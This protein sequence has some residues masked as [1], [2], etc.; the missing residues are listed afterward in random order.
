MKF[1]FSVAILFFTLLCTAAAQHIPHGQRTYSIAPAAEKILID[2]LETE[3]T[4][5]NAVSQSGFRQHFPSDTMEARY[6]TFVKMCYDDQAL[7]VYAR[8]Q[9]DSTRKYVVATLRRDFGTDANDYF[10]LVI[11]PYQDYTNGFRFMVNAFGAQEES[12]LASGGN[13]NDEPR[14][15]CKWQAAVKRSPSE[16]TAEIRIP[17]TSL[18]Y[19]PKNR[20]WRINFIRSDAASNERSVWN[21]VPLAFRVF[22]LAYTGNLDWKAH[23]PRPG[24]N[25]SVIPYALGGYTADKQN[26]SYGWKWNVG[27]DLKFS[28]TP[29]LNLDLTINPDF[30][31]VDVD[32][33][34]TNLTRFDLYFP[35][36]RLFFIEN[37]DLFARFGFS[38]IRPFF[39]RRIGLYRGNQV[40]I[41]AGVRLSG[42]LDDNWRIGIM[43]VQ[44][45]GSKALQKGPENYITLTIQRKVFKRSALGFIFVNRQGFTGRRINP[46]N[47]NRIAGVDLDY[48]NKDNTLTGK[49]FFHHSFQPGTLQDAF[50]H[51]SYLGFTNLRWSAMWNHEYVGRN[52]NADSLGFVPRQNIYDALKKENRK[53]AY[54][55]LEPSLSHYWYPKR[56]RYIFRY[57]AGLYW[58]YYADGRFAATDVNYNPFFEI[59]FRDNSIFSVG[60]NENFT[61]LFYFT[62]VL[63]R[64]ES[65]TFLSPGRYHYRNAYVS[66]TSNP[67]KVM[68]GDVS[69][70]GG[71]FFNGELYT[72]TTGLNYRAQPW[73]IFSLTA[74]YDRLK[75][76]GM[77]Q[78]QT[79][80]LA[81]PRIEINPTRSV[82]FTLFTQYNTQAR[83]LNVYTRLQWRYAPMSDLFLVYTDNY[84]T[85]G[86][87]NK[88]RGIVL[89]L[90]Y[91]FQP[92]ISGKRRQNSTT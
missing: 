32:R 82:F 48:A 88:N 20:Q 29:T 77:S 70:Q 30:S 63:G 39:S 17:F 55:R 37:S 45:A 71:T 24:V 46:Y 9:R 54:W 73:G 83:N 66:Y 21:P 89:K 60:Y 72:V 79:L 10:A 34:V 56:N 33:Q 52:Y 90:V 68:Y 76:P 25:F 15:D 81:G 92:R 2:G 22:S 80:L 61:R 65:S 35:E 5:R 62:D 49:F 58:N 57:T 1:F 7:Y 12:L 38:K 31:Q 16:W 8:C 13:Y 85:S 36:Q 19:H 3:S 91:W 47:Y 42:K 26:N 75:L 69:L 64:D 44:T 11:E 18:R 43:S 51:A 84:D 67:R 87:L 59:T 78:A 86:F 74:S 14:W 53:M 27:G 50:A 4:W 6:Q 40:P 28:I 23:S 41:L